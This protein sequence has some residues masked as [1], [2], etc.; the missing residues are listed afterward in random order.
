MAIQAYISTRQTFVTRISG[1][2]SCFWS[3]YRYM[4]AT[5]APGS[6]DPH[7]HSAC[8]SVCLSTRFDHLET[9]DFNEIWHT[10]AL[11]DWPGNNES[12]LPNSLNRCHGNRKT[13]QN[14]QFSS[15]GRHCCRTEG[16]MKILTRQI[17]DQFIQYIPSKS[18][19]DRIKIV[20]EDTFLV[21]H[22]FRCC[23]RDHQMTDSAL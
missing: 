8:L 10:C 18:V 11:M 4:V 14:W 12:F 3:P 16:W 22:L 21:K 20:G 17:I 23:G 9:F 19:E 1:C 13:F 2:N 15:L 6:G 7:R 5:A